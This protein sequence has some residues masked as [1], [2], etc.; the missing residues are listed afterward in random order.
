MRGTSIRETKRV[1][2]LRCLR[3]VLISLYSVR[4]RGLHLVRPREVNYFADYGNPKSNFFPDSI[5]PLSWEHSV[6]IIPDYRSILYSCIELYRAADPSRI[7]IINIQVAAKMQ[8]SSPPASILTS[9]HTL[10]TLAKV[11][12]SELQVVPSP[13]QIVSLSF[14]PQP[15]LEPSNL[16]RYGTIFAVFLI[17]V[18]AFLVSAIG[19]RFFRL[20]SVPGPFW[21]AYS[22]LWL[23][24]ALASG[25][26]AKIFVDV[27]KTYGE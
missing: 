5:C 25:E 19:A 21:A 17:P 6:A 3:F 4:K 23:V 2:R 8:Y 1:L 27:N 15:I 13:Q 16:A 24:R 22:R 26:S 14:L 20:R 10:L 7:L 11:N 18:L 12:L 9:R